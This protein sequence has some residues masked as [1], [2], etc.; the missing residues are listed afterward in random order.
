MA[1]GTTN[2][3]SGGNALRFVTEEIYSSTVWTM[4]ANV[5]KDLITVMVFGGGGGG[6]YL[7]GSGKS[8]GGGGGGHMAKGSF[9]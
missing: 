2:A 4:P 8:G 1:Y 6:G 3:G 7:G 9:T 5:Y